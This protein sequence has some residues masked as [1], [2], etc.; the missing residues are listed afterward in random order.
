MTR[1]R[2]WYLPDPELFAVPEIVN[3]LEI[4]EAQ[5]EAQAQHG[6]RGRS[7]D[8]SVDADVDDRGVL[9]S[10]RIPRNLLRGAHPERICRSVVE[11]VADA[12]HQVSRRA[13]ERAEARV[14]LAHSRRRRS[15]R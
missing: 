5:E 1:T 12:R 10:L 9:L 8:E 7:R 14:G 2:R 13:N 3:P 15:A 4:P 6:T 11:A